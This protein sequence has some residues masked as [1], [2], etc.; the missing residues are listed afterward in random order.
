MKKLL[1]Y[2]LILLPVQMFAQENQVIQ[3]P[4]AGQILERVAKK[5]NSLSSLQTDFEL[6]IHDRKDG[7]R[8][9]SKG[10]LLLKKEKYRLNSEGSMV[11]FDGTTMWTFIPENNEVTITQPELTSGNFLSNPSSF[12]DSYKEDFK[13]RYVREHVQN[14]IICQEL[15][16]F[17]K[18]LN[19]PYSR[20][21]V[22]VN[23][24]TDLPESISSI[25][26]D[27]V[28]YIVSLKNVVIN[29]LIADSEFTFNPSKHK[30]IEIVDMRGL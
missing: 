24:T 27:G 26:K 12:F 11:Y 4:V 30:K 3:D 16:L 1:I 8:T 9:T 17:P 19:Q 28:D 10:T 7:T 22:I 21:K 23:K 13:Y 25:G 29:K 14:G 5:T 15:D 20:I 18:N 6:V 2:C